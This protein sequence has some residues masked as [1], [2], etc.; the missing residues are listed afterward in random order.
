MQKY[1]VIFSGELLP[2]FDQ[3]DVERN[4]AALFNLDDAR[5]ARIFSGSTVTLKRDLDQAGAARFEA[6]LAKAGA[7]VE[8]QPNPP[9]PS[10][11]E[12]DSDNAE[13]DAD[14]WLANQVQS[15]SAD[16]VEPK[17]PVESQTHPDT[18]PAVEVAATAADI[19]APDWSVAP[20]GSSVLA[21]NE[22]PQTAPV[23]VSVDHITIA[24]AGSDVL[25]PDERRKIEAVEVDVSH[26]KIED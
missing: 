20:V 23:E 10:A 25:N 18:P 13:N 1:D 11:A 16:G 4:V 5:V 6:A 17:V 9:L 21:E 22:R 15:P 8:L 3:A 2:G 19:A 12:Q 7:R 26:L 14:Q 24:P